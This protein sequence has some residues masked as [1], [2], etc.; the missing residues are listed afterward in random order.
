MKKLVLI[1]IV[2]QASKLTAQFYKGG[3]G[4]NA[5]FQVPAT[6]REV[7]MGNSG[8]ATSRGVFAP[9]WNPANTAASDSADT[10]R[11]LVGFVGRT[12]PKSTESSLGLN[13]SSFGGEGFKYGYFGYVHQADSLFFFKFRISTGFNL[14]YRGID[15]L[16]QT[17]ISEISREI[18]TERSFNA[19]EWLLIF[20]LA[21]PELISREVAIGLNLRLDFLNYSG[22]ETKW[23]WGLDF[24]LRYRYSFWILGDLVGGGV[25]RYD[26][27]QNSQITVLTGMSKRINFSFLQSLSVDIYAGNFTPVKASIGSEGFLVQD[28]LILRFGGRLGRNTDAENSDILFDM[29]T[30][31]IGFD[32]S[33]LDIFPRLVLDFAYSHTF[34]DDGQFLELVDSPIKFGLQMEF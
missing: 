7:A 15:N 1:L 34:F 4:P 25:I 12:G 18:V 29:L 8:V 3:G 16:W 28:I 21:S 32:L 31:G 20:N 10:L 22:I 30:V 17:R 23:S 2:F 13:S 33:Q 9:Y 14:I 19:D 27:S 24:G 11:N 26:R 5:F 6:P